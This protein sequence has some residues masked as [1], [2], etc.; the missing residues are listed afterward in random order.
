MKPRSRSAALQLVGGGFR[1]GGGQGGEGGES[2]RIGLNDRVQ[3]IV[4]LPCKPHGS[5]RGEPL[6]GRRA[7]RQHLQVDPR[8]IHLAQTQ[9]ADIEQPLLDF[10]LTVRLTSE[11]R[12]G[13]IGVKVV[14]FEC[15]DERFAL[16]WRNGLRR[17]KLSSRS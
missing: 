9:R 14:L 6:R 4:C 10:G 3:P 1:R 11:K 8:L 12:R 2:L 5:L 7:V 16:H 17:M 13:E 15:D